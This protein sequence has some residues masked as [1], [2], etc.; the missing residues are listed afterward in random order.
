MST[1]WGQEP[2]GRRFDIW[3]AEHAD[4]WRWVT[5]ANSDVG[6]G[7][8][9]RLWLLPPDVQPSQ[10][11]PGTWDYFD[12]G[13]VNGEWRKGVTLF[14]VP[15]YT[16]DM[17]EAWKLALR[18]GLMVSPSM[19]AGWCAGQFKGATGDLDGGRRY[20]VPGTWAE[21]PFASLAICRAASLVIHQLHP[22]VGCCEVEAAT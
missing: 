19:T 13:T 17:G 3:M 18:Y 20:C 8:T 15:R 12:H 11:R 1:K 9:P 21:A 7:K 22:G 6:D 14:D 16:E 4:G 2:A 10:V 5:G